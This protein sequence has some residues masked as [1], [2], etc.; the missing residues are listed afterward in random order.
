MK[1]DLSPL[2][3]REEKG[4]IRVQ[5]HPTLPL[6]I[7]NYTETCQFS[8]A[9]DEW[10]LQARGLITDLEGNVVARPFKKFFNY[11]EHQGTLPS[12]APEIIEK[13]DGSLGIMFWYDGAWHFATRGSFTSDQAIHA[14]EILRSKYNDL[15]K[16]PWPI[17]HT[18]LFEIIY[19]AN[20]IVIDYK[21]ADELVHL[22]S[23]LVEEG[24]ESSDFLVLTGCPFRTPARFPN[25]DWR[26]D[27]LKQL[28]TPDN[29]EGFVLRW[30]DGFR[31]KFKFEEYKR[32]HRI[33]TGTST[34][35]I[36]E[37]IRDGKSLDELINKTPD[38]FHAWV[39]DT[40]DQIANEMVMIR[41]IVERQVAWIEI[42]KKPKD[43]KEWADI[44]KTMSFP[45]LMFQALDKRDLRP[46]I[47]KKVRPIHSK[48]FSQEV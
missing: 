10:T 22:G 27:T 38:E 18:H 32:L 45:D 14:R 6:L 21:G 20:R 44:I 24:R 3:E 15:Q 7:W 39:K 12:E 30:P 16:S 19:P 28:V 8:K 48:P 33:M 11:E 5:Q 40:Y 17:T 34:L 46:S 4:L 23:I 31:L 41:T 36:W 37:F 25:A 9:W 1:L 13:M 35:T 42:Y 26:S 43:R 47:V 2:R 29:R